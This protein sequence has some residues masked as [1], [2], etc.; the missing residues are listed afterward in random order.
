MYNCTG[1]S[2][3]KKTLA[4]PGFEAPSTSFS[5]NP[6]FIAP[7]FLWLPKLWLFTFKLGD[8]DADDYLIKSV[9]AHI[10]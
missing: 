6:K 5:L 4:T 1:T 9:E 10:R 3:Y 8:G 2:A 7:A